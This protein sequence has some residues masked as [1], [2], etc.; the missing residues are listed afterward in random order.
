MVVTPHS[1]ELK[2]FIQAVLDTGELTTAGADVMN[3]ALEFLNNANKEK[4]ETKSND[5][6]KRE[7]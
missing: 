1:N 6:D 5:D 3:D 7:E 2:D 4:K